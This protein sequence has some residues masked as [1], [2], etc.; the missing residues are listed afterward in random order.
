MRSNSTGARIALGL[1]TGS[2]AVAGVSVNRAQAAAIETENNLF[3]VD[4]RV[5]GVAERCRLDTGDNTTATL[6]RSRA[7]SKLPV[8]NVG[9]TMGVSGVMAATN[10]VH[11]DKISVS[12]ISLEDL[13]NVQ[14]LTRPH[15]FSSLGLRFFERLG[16]VTFDFRRGEFTRERPP[17]GRLCAGPLAVD[18]V[19]RIPVRIGGQDLSAAWD[20]GASST[21]AD[22]GY[23]EAHPELFEFVRELPRGADSTTTG[24]PARLFKAR[25]L[26]VCGRE[27]QDVSVV[28]MDMSA[29]KAMI[30]DFPDV[31]LGANLMVG[32]IWAFDFTARTWSFE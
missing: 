29:P 22:A 24:V 5:D 15:P 13:D 2:L 4:C 28:A 16:T 21:V 18:Y 23:V 9:K 20:T 1:L 19:M 6:R 31:T 12:E 32:R 27:F 14:V 17:P 8:V 26:S 30:P 3:F 25:T 7:F 10:L 11:V